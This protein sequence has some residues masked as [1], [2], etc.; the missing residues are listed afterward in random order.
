MLHVLGL[1]N[2]QLRHSVFSGND[3]TRA[4]EIRFIMIRK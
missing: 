1:K 3:S 2:S 4:G